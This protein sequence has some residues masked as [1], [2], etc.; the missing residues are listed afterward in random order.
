[1]S[2]CI[3]GV[4]EITPRGSY[5]GQGGYSGRRDTFRLANNNEIW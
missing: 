3:T 5:D 1:M 2:P 4:A